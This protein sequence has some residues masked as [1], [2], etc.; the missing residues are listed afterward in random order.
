MDVGD[1]PASFRLKPG[2]HDIQIEKAG[3]D[4][5][6]QQVNAAAGVPRNIQAT[7]EKPPV[8]KAA[9]KPT[10]KPITKRPAGAA[11]AKPKS[12]ATHTP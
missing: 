1:T 6:K 7:L 3:F 8:P 12:G 5:W 10:A 11:T 9:V 4:V 2:D